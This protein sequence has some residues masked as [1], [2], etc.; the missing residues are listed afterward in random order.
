VDTLKKEKKIM[1]ASTLSHIRILREHLRKRENPNN[2]KK[3]RHLPIHK[4]SDWR[5]LLKPPHEAT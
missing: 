2:D 3:T 1:E 4:I 5:L